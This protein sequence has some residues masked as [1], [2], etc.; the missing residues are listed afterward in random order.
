MSLQTQHTAQKLEI[1]F[2]YSYPWGE[3]GT[4]GYTV[5]TTVRTLVKNNKQ[6]KWIENKSQ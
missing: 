5:Y 2:Y 6:I 1:K 4:P 3:G